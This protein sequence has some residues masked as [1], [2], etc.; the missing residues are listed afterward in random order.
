[1]AAGSTGTLAVVNSTKNKINGRE[2]SSGHAVI[3]QTLGLPQSGRF[4]PCQTP[5]R[6]L[7]G[8]YFPAEFN[9][10]YAAAGVG[11]SIINPEYDLH[12]AVELTA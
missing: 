10:G 12:P 6:V 9:E 2:L 11:I 1:M 3:T 7:Q 5:I 4:G 8:L